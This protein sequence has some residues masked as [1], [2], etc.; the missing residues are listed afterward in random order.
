MTLDNPVNF[1]TY[2]LDCVKYWSQ[3]TTKRIVHVTRR[4]LVD[5]QWNKCP[6]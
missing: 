1:H 2:L 6:C 5:F 3:M 4:F